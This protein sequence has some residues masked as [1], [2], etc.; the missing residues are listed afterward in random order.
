[1][2][3]SQARILEWAAISPSR[4]SSP[5]RVWTHISCVSCIA[6]RF[7]GEY[8]CYY[9]ITTLLS[10]A[11][12]KTQPTGPVSPPQSLSGSAPFPCPRGLV[13]S[14]LSIFNLHQYSKLA[15]PWGS[16]LFFFLR[17][18][19]TLTLLPISHTSHTKKPRKSV[20]SKQADDTGSGTPVCLF[21]Y[22][23]F[24]VKPACFESKI[25]YGLWHMVH[26]SHLVTFP[27]PDEHLNLTSHS[28]LTMW[29][30]SD[31]LRSS[32]GMVKSSLLQKTWTRS[33]ILELCTMTLG[34]RVLTESPPS[35]VL[36]KAMATHSS[37]LAWKI[38]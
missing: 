8:C 23:L 20:N 12:Y 32:L 34:L 26:L 17:L 27:P 22:F 3:F 37:T 1:M 24:S 36:E 38:P 5:P 21:I 11:F 19:G 25:F 35:A 6:G 2:G 7:I 29:E 28:C 15:H 33:A 4:K 30:P 14:Q 10:R 16:Y 31:M 13:I 18:L 9:N